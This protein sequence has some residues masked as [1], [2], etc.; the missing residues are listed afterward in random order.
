MR[1]VPAPPASVT[2]WQTSCYFP[3]H[4]YSFLCQL[5]ANGRQR[6]HIVQDGDE[7]G[8]KGGFCHLSMVLG[9][10]RVA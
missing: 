3:A 8:W 10:Q 7:E 5:P 9:G 2:T 6:A 1:E 4:S